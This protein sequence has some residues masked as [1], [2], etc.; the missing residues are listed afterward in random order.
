MGML[1]QIPEKH[2]GYLLGY[3]GLC[4][5]QGGSAYKEWSKPKEKEE[6]SGQK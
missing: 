5:P 2:G 6:K 1:L 4:L 3:S